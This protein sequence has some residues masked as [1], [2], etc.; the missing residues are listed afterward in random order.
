MAGCIEDLLAYSLGDLDWLK[1][2]NRSPFEDRFQDPVHITSMLLLQH[3][4]V[5]NATYDYG[6]VV[7]GSSWIARKSEVKPNG[8]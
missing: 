1:D 3:I 6:E 4:D 7:A 5:A 2:F 8:S